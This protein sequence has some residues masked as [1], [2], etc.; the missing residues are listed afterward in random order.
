MAWL[1]SPKQLCP[2][3]LTTPTR[4]RVHL[5][6]RRMMRL[7]L[8]DRYVAWDR[9]LRHTPADDTHYCD[10]VICVVQVVIGG[11]NK[12]LINGVNAN[13]L[14]VQD[15]FCSVGLNVNNPHF[16]IMQVTIIIHW[17]KTFQVLWPEKIYIYEIISDVH[18]LNH[19]TFD[20]KWTWMADSYFYFTSVMWNL[21]RTDCHKQIG[22]ILVSCF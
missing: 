10:V 21:L 7:L 15:L 18:I 14:R 1:G 6:L 4:N 9:C 11:R 22:F 17:F 5:G 13:N 12:Y 8:H 3:L 2:S 19:R 16:L 20:L